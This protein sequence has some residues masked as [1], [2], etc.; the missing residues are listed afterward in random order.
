MKDIL[1]SEIYN[2]SWSFIWKDF[3]YL[4]S[5]SVEKCREMQDLMCPHNSAI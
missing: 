4:R 5:I 2:S 3:N 1:K